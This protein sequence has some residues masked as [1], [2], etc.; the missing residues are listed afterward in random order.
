MKGWFESGPDAALAWAQTAKHTDYEDRMAAEVLTLS[1]A[2]DPQKL[3]ASLLTFPAGDKRVK[4][5]LPTYFELIGTTTGNPDPAAIYENIPAPLR[6]AAWP[7]AMERLT[8]ADL[9]AAVDWLTAHINDP[10]RDYLAT[11]RLLFTLAGPD[12]S[13][14]AQWAA[15]LPDDITDKPWLHPACQVTLLWLAKD[16]TSAEAWLHTQPSTLHWVES[17]LRRLEEKE[18]AKEPEADKTEK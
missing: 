3:V 12:P 14:T 13:G 5:C 15:T 2:G 7:I 10:G 6:E 4:E 18:N 17:T 8:A 9:Q 1:A 16:R 11:Y